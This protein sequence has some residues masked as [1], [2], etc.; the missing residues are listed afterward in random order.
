MAN[1]YNYIDSNAKANH[2]LETI[3]NEDINLW[4]LKPYQN[5]F[6]KYYVDAIAEEWQHKQ[7]KGEKFDTLTLVG[8]TMEYLET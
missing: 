6:D 2:I 7:M 5:C 1:T 8:L 4:T 3:K